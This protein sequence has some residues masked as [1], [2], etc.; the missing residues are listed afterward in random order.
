M[1]VTC[2][3]A[4]RRSVRRPARYVHVRTLQLQDPPNR[5]PIG[6]S[7]PTPASGTPTPTPNGVPARVSFGREH[8]PPAIRPRPSLR[9]SSYNDPHL[10]LS[11][12]FH[13]SSLSLSLFSSLSIFRSLL[14]P[15]SPPCVK[16]ENM[17]NHQTALTAKVTHPSTQRCLPMDSWKTDWDFLETIQRDLLAL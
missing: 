6:S 15:L 2:V 16:H 11:L 5:L 12:L 1:R 13:T 14:L 3:Y 10:R 8:H 4:R 7:T 17:H 9:P